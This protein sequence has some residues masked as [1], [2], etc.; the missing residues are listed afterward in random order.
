VEKK[1]VGRINLMLKSSSGLKWPGDSYFRTLSCVVKKSWLGRTG[2]EIPSQTLNASPEHS[3]VAWMHAIPWRP[4][5]YAWGRGWTA[6]S[7]LRWFTQ[8]PRVAFPC[9]C[10]CS[11]E[12][13]PSISFFLTWR[14]V[15]HC[16]CCSVAVMSNSL[17]PH[18]LQYTRPPWP[19]PS[20]R[21]CSSSCSLHWF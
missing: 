3:R 20:P 12:L 10:D 19:L 5:K 16:C 15:S 2:T 6:P 11:P 13:E 7:V 17:R 9:F 8:V 18:G 1:N 14:Q 4:D 21:V